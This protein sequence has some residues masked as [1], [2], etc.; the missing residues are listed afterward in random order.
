MCERIIQRKKIVALAACIGFLLAEISLAQ[1]P[2]TPPAFRTSP[3]A[4]EM[5]TGETPPEA[6]QPIEPP[7]ENLMPPDMPPQES[8]EDFVRKRPANLPPPPEP[9]PE[10]PEQTEARDET[11][12][13]PEE[14]LE[15]PSQI[16]LSQRDW[17]IFGTEQLTEFGRADTSLNRKWSL[18]PHVS[19]SAVYDNNIFLSEHKESD[20]ILRMAPG[21]AFRIGQG[22]GTLYLMGDY[23]FAAVLFADHSSENSFDHMASLAA[24]WTLQRVTFRAY[25]NMR[26]DSGTSVDVGDRVQ[27][28]SYSGG[29]MANYV[30][31]GKT[32]FDL[33][34][35]ENISDNKGL[36]G[37]ADTRMH[38]Y[39]NYQI[40]PKINVGVG[41]ALG[42]LTVQNGTDQTY[43][44]ASLQAN[45]AATAKI[46]ISGNVGVEFRQ[47]DG[48][49]ETVNPVFAIGLAWSIREGTR[50]DVG[51]RRRI[52]SS[53]VSG[54]ENYVAT[55]VTIGI[56]QRFTGRFDLSLSTGFENLQYESTQE[57]V[58]A[59][60]E[61]NYVFLRPGIEWR[62]GDRV[63]LGIFYEYSQSVSSGS[64]SKGFQR[65]RVG[66]QGDMAF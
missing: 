1:P 36:I 2:P 57:G 32:S 26:V 21:I 5:P 51:T 20:F 16:E 10:S 8:D 6:V 25:A 37:S 42:I 22:D 52:F 19:V 38:G 13:Q 30:L 54:G 45:Y 56:R 62:F 14:R 46:A 39:V 49:G 31:T 59:N 66:V 35:D 53:A 3:A 9:E 43:E 50:I 11:P 55:G 33:S 7:A 47:F 65:S 4:T 17:A 34:V 23:T 63:G 18:R 41:G 64:G 61:D 58:S 12:V 24:Q 28:R 29:I 15:P 60:R 44:E 27:R 48:G 40:R